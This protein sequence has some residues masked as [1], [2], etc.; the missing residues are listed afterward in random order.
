M[1][2]ALG[3]ILPLGVA[4]ALSSVPLALVTTVLLSVR[5]RPN[6]I[7]LAVGYAA[8]SVALPMGFAAGLGSASIWEGPT[9][10]WVPAALEIL[11]GIALVVYGLSVAR[12]PRRTGRPL[13]KLPSVDRVPTWIAATVGVGLGARPKAL[14][15]AAAAGVA[16]ARADVPLGQQLVAGSV[17]AALTISSVA[18]PVVFVL[19][20]GDPAQRSLVATRAFVSRHGKTV[21]SLAA[22]LIGVVVVANGLGAIG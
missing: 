10:R 21:T 7:A 15:L 4:G 2:S 6:G 9:R 18:L 11:I 17:Y 22:A 20:R 3:P 1:L 19:V 13:F 5:A 12:H 16:I 14:L 8:S